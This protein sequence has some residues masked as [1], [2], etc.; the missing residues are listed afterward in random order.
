LFGADTAQSAQEIEMEG[1]DLV[2]RADRRLQ[3][4]RIAEAQSFNSPFS[5]YSEEMIS[6]RSNTARAVEQRRSLKY[7]KKETSV[8]GQGTFL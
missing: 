2:L 8:E 3:K 7:P 4:V 5:D 6:G 1:D